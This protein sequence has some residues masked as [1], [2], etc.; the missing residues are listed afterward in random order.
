VDGPPREERAR[1]H[2]GRGSLTAAGVR[3]LRGVGG[4]AV[5]FALGLTAASAA[6]QEAPLALDTVRVEVVSRVSAAMPVSTRGVQVIDRAVLAALPVRSVTEALHLA[7]GA[8][9]M[10][11]SRAQADLALRGSSYEQVLVLVDGVRVGDPQ[12]GHFHL[13]LAVPLDQIERIEVLR[14]AA[15]ALYGAEAVGGVVNV[16]TR[17]AGEGGVSLRAE[18]GTFATSVL[19]GTLRAALGGAML[20]VAGEHDRSDGHR[21]GT[22]HRISQARAALQAPIA[23]RTLRAQVAHAAR[24]FGADGFYAPFPSYEETRTST[25]G[26]D[27]L[28]SPATAR[29]VDVRLSHRQHDDDFVLCRD[30]PSFYRNLHTSRVTGAEV[31]G[32]TAIGGVRLAGGASG[33]LE[34][35]RSETLG[36]RDESRG[37][38]F[39]EAVAEPRSDVVVTAGLR[40]DWHSE[41]GAVAAPSL[42]AAWW[43][44]PAIR[45]RASLDRGIRAP[46]WTERFY[47]DPSNVGSPDLRPERAWSADFGAEVA[48]APAIRL[49]A[50]VWARDADGLIDWVRPSGTGEPWTSR[51]VARARFAGTELE[52]EVAVGPVTLSGQATLTRFEAP[53][54]DGLES[55]YALR[56][57]TRTLALGA[58]GPLPYGLDAAARMSH[59]RRAS[60]AAPVGAPCMPG[61]V[62]ASSTLDARVRR[63]FGAARVHADLRN[64]LN[65]R[66]CDVVGMPASGRAVTVGVEV[67][68]R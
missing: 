34:S 52:A 29:G 48:P 47:R 26:I 39:G 13:D 31:V 63:T 25:V 57:L 43:A 68:R 9:P 59:A 17:R 50:A 40:G 18:H 8:D 45:F 61:D 55:K 36:D 28:G 32:R 42:A 41:Y 4:S 19:A 6:S 21:P 24:D 56:P 44:S 46:T 2:G 67:G 35:L 1:R 53:E 37:A 30:D 38:V 12:T 66:G 60:D 62:D 14:G 64:A 7:L 23:G 27:W 22:D 11:R 58:S 65:T 20:D 51:N 10:P 3:R 15:S 5:A 54:A 33:A 16:V 49:A